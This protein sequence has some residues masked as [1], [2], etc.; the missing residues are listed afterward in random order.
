MMTSKRARNYVC[1]SCKA[2]QSITMDL[3]ISALSSE[4]YFCT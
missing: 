2:L 1:D 4:S 3:Q